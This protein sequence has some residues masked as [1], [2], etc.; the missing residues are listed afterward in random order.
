ME[1]LNL[2]FRSFSS[3]S[4]DLFSDS[5]VSDFFDLR[6]HMTSESVSYS[7]YV[8]LK[9]LEMDLLENLYAQALEE[10]R[11]CRSK[12]DTKMDRFTRKILLHQ[13]TWVI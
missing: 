9:K 12:K 4:S 5:L 10:L 13:L 6:N 11:F 3:S 8:E 2:S 1:N 7:E